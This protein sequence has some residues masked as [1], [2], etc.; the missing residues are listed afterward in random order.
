MKQ[1]NHWKKQTKI[2]VCIL[3]FLFFVSL[4]CAD[5]AFF[6]TLKFY[7]PALG[8]DSV[9]LLGYSVGYINP[10]PD[11]PKSA[12][13]QIRLY[14]SH[15]DLISERNHQVIFLLFGRFVRE[16]NQTISIIPMK[17]SRDIKHIQVYRKGTLL[18]SRK[19]TELCNGNGFCD[20]K[21]NYYSCSTDCKSYSADGV[22]VPVGD[23]VCDPD[24]LQGTDPDCYKVKPIEVSHRPMEVSAE[25][26]ERFNV[27]IAIAFL[28]FMCAL[29]LSFLYYKRRHAK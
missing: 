18:L 14:D 25:V 19:I 20:G 21:E 17:Y 9:E 2:G 26:E 28:A 15:G 29:L 6:V 11:E 13:Y 5:K 7:N 12:D 23:F 1:L 24:C 27:W 4:V 22:C 10:W 3:I 8:N 16:L